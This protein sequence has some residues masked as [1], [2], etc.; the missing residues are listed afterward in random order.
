[1]YEAKR[2]LALIKSAHESGRSENDKIVTELRSRH[3]VEVDALAD[4]N[5]NLQLQV[6]EQRD[7]ETIRRLRREVDE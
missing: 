7:Q 4:E 2:Q 6:D 3:K 1:L 5:H